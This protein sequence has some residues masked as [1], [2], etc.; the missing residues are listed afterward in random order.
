MRKGKGMSSNYN[1]PEAVAKRTAQA[2][3]LLGF[4]T[5]FHQALVRRRKQ[6]NDRYINM[7]ISDSFA[8]AHGA[9]DFHLFDTEE[10][11]FQ[12]YVKCAWDNDS[13]H[14]RDRAGLGHIAQVED[15]T[16]ENAQVLI[17]VMLDY[18]YAPIKKELP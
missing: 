9:L 4:I 15:R 6:T 11:N 14:V 17:E 10:R 13:V 12:L 7:R 5:L 16:P 1:N 18:I 2:E 3:Y 8:S